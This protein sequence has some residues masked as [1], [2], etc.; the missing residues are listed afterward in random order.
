VPIAFNYQDLIHIFNKTFSAHFNTLLVAGESEPIYHP[1]DQQNP[2]HRIIFAN[3]FYASAL[4]EIA[5]WLV[6][7]EK[8]VYKLI[9]VI[10]MSP[11]AEIRSNKLN[12]KK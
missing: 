10:G 12:L 6:A 1:K 4:H 5:H 3:G 2:Q 9:M 8:D 7:G 11:M